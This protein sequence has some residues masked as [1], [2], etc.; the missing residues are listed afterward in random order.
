MGEEGIV[1][2]VQRRVWTMLLALPP[3]VK[4][5]LRTWRGMPLVSRAVHPVRWGNLRR[6]S[7][8]GT[9]SGAQRGTPID[10]HYVDRFVQQRG[11]FVRGRVLEAETAERTHRYGRDVERVDVL[12]VDAY[13]DDVTLLVDLAD[14]GSLPEAA[15]DCVL[16]VH[17]LTR[18]TNV[19]VAL[20]NAWGS[21]A[22]GGALLVSVPTVRAVDTTDSGRGVDT[23]RMLP[24]G[25]QEILESRCPD[26][27]VDVEGFGNVL[28]ATA[29]LM[30]VAAEELRSS[31][32]DHHDPDH[33]VVACACVVKR[34]ST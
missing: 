9:R 22:R 4:D 12:D 11:G 27:D 1:R 32:L 19:D 10:L 31:E 15:F 28:A 30:G 21:V 25:L 17:V 16:L 26:G 29:L 8:I 33:P 2:G 20:S 13:N 7:P 18:V 5:R 3:P 23:W 24:A 6:V 34:G 14:A